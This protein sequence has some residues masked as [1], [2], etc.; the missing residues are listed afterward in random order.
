MPAQP[1]L[2]DPAIVAAVLTVAAAVLTMAVGSNV[3]LWFRVGRIEGKVDQALEA[4]HRGE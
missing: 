2:I 1:P 4:R 3:A